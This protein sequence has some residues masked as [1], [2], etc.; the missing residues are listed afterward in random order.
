MRTRRRRKPRR[1]SEDDRILQ[2]CREAGRPLLP[3]EL[4]QSVQVPAAGPEAVEAAVARLINQGKLVAL[5]GGRVGLAEEMN[6][7]VGELSVHPDG[8]GFVTPEK[9]GKDIYITAVNLKEAW[10]GDRVVVRLEGTRG[11]RREGRVIRI[12]ERGVREVL[13]LLGRADET[14]FVAPE[15]E[16]L[17]FNLIIAPEQLNGAAPGQVV[18][19]AVTHYPTGHLNPQGAV[20]EVLGALEDAEVQ[21]RLVLLKRGIPDEFPPEVLAAAAKISPDFSPKAIKGRL[22]LRELP[23]VTIDGEHARDFDDG[24]YV[25]KKPGGAY[26]L[27]VSIADV[28]FY[29][30]PDSALD[31]EGWE[32][33]NSVYFPQRAV[34]MLPPDLATDI[35][36]LRPD[37]DR[38]AVTVILDYDRRGRLQKPKFARTVVRNHARL[39]YLLVNDLLDPKNRKLRS[40]FRPFLQMLGWMA[41]LTQLLRE[42]RAERGS[43]L[44]SLPEAEVVLDD[45]G[46]PVDVRRVDL[47]ISHQIIEEFMIAANEAVA[48][49]LAEPCLFRVHERPD[50]AK[51]AAFRTYLKGLSFDLPKEA[52]RDPRALRQFLDEVRATPLAPMV[53]LMLLRSLKQARYAG[54]NLGHYGLATEWYTHFTSPIRRYPDL[55]V[56]RL[57][58]AKMAGKKPPFSTEPDDLEAVAQHLN[59]R[60]RVGIEA[61]R[62]MLARMQVRCLAHRVGE[63]FT[64]R[65]TG[66]NAFGFFVSLDEIYAEGLVRLVDLPNDYFKYDEA[67]QRLLGRRTRKSFALG[68]PVTVKV[69]HVD[70]RR[71]HVNLVLAEEGAEG[72]DD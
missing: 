43:L 12:L 58:L 32:R 8:F 30:S 22:D 59:K 2:A 38:L 23:M 65:I 61:E 60:E 40:G 53:Q 72:K 24:V 46:W 64:G 28:S 36:S 51:M 3:G 7:A 54:E 25:E 69:A 57:L 15:D 71:R 49:Y 31:R 47:L 55:Q 5:K 26:T 20:I 39:T 62:E 70:I 9:G 50:A 52:H 4:H 21:T 37:V 45:K 10:H 33:G 56:H 6:L 19:A 66:V 35:C 18:R 41:E 44:M 67:R 14:Y 63:T 48:E 16:H 34:H 1:P 27:Y 29:V 17:I 13:G 42:R 68:D 11:R